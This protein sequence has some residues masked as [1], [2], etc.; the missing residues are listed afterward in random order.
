MSKDESLAKDGFSSAEHEEGNLT[1]NLDELSY[2]PPG[3][4]GVFASSYVAMCAAFA[5]IGGLLFGYE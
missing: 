3:I 4:R 2:G 1:L 5:T